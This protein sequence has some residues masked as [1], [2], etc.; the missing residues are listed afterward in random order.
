MTKRYFALAGLGVIAAAIYATNASWLAPKPDG[1]PILIAQRGVAQVFDRK[2]VDETSCTARHIPPPAHSFIAN[3]LPSMEAAFAEGADGVELDLSATADGEFVAFHDAGLD[4]Q[5]DGHGPL[6]AQSFAALKKLDVGYG[7]TADGG[8][9]Y[10]LRGKGV[11]LMPSL[12]EVLAAFPGRSFLIQLKQGPA[13]MAPRLVGYLDAHHADWSKL[14]FFGRE[15]RLAALRKLRPDARVW[16]DKA[17]ARCSFDYLLQGWMGYVPASC[18]RSGTIAVSLAQ[19]G[20]AWG[21]PNRF[22]QRMQA[23]KV[24][25]LVIGGLDGPKATGF[26]R[27]DSARDLARLPA[28][29]PVQVWT[30]HVEVVGPLLRTRD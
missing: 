11:G 28:G 20:L 17:A 8:R 29:A 25:I 21:W 13:D 6:G 4:C 10:P 5:T 30:D 2:S 15:D 23:N 27:V 7:F 19:A 22:V 24:S 1:R 16:S 26:W 12:A 14:A 18:R 3:T 9:T